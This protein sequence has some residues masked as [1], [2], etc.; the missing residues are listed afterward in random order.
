MP[1]TA[2]FLPLLV[3]YG[4]TLWWCVER[5]NAPTQYFAHCWLVPLVAAAILWFRRAQWRSVPRRTDRGGLWL[6]VPGLVLHLAGALL[7]VDSWSAASLVLTVPGAAWLALG[8]ERLRGLWPVLWLVLFVVPTPI[9]VEGRAAFELKEIAVEGGVAVANVFG[10][11][12]E[13]RGDLLLASGVPGSLWVADACGGLRS[14]LAMLTLA[15]CVAFFTGKAHWPRRAGLLLLAPLLAIGANVA[16]IALLCGLLRGF[17]VEFAQ[18]TGHDLANVVEWLA[19]LAMLFGVDVLLS[20]LTPAAAALPST[21]P[22]TGVATPLAAP[23]SPALAPGAGLRRYAWPLW[24]LAAPFLLLSLYRPAPGPTDRAEALPAQLA[25]YTL[26]PRDAAAEAAFREA[27]PRWRELL[28]TRD[29]V[30]RQYRDQRGWPIYLT[31]LF[32]DTNWKSV[33]PPRICIEGSGMDIEV[34]D[35]VRAQGFAADAWI[36]RIVAKRRR[37]GARFV[38]LSLFGAGDWVSGDYWDFTWHHLPRALLR[39]NVSGFLLRVETPI[40]PGE[41][42]RAAAGRCSV[43][44]QALLPVAQAQLR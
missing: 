23:A 35:L 4:V 21:P 12:I 38:T 5:W 25:G 16:R 43:F 26:W 7:M 24:G 37:D 8:R 31:A 14:L 17:G 18:G 42:D 44:L 6:L 29:F 32:H 33:H 36:S 19:L 11:G 34:D 2:I 27:L 10:A 30:H 15:Y 13:R 20:R 3:A 9:Y 28:G 1:F 41:N 40:A 39:A 22:S